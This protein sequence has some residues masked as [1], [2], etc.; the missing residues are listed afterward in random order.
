MQTK[1]KKKKQYKG[2]TYLHMK[3][4]KTNVK[5]KFTRMIQNQKHHKKNSMHVW[6]CFNE[7]WNA[8]LTTNKDEKK[9]IKWKEKK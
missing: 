6:F 1:K 4:T 2:N 5:M 7:N 3:K 9:Q 8:T